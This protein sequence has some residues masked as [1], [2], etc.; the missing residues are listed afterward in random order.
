MGQPLVHC[1]VAEKNNIFNL[2]GTKT[3]NEEGGK[4]PKPKDEDETSCAM[5]DNGRKFLSFL[6]SWRFLSGDFQREGPPNLYFRVFDFSLRPRKW[7]SHTNSHTL[8]VPHRNHRRGGSSSP[9]QSH[10]QERPPRERERLS[11]TPTVGQELLST[12]VS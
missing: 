10:H 4:G 11:P 1:R 2:T 5:L 3:N 12:V 7:C 9:T 6:I 8:C